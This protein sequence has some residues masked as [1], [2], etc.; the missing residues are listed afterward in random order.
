MSPDL[1]QI[2]VRLPAELRARLDELSHSSQ[3]SLSELIRRAVTMYVDSGADA[4][5]RVEAA[6][7]K[8]GAECEHAF[9]PEV[10]LYGQWMN[11]LH[12][13]ARNF[14]RELGDYLSQGGDDQPPRGMSP[15]VLTQ[16]TTGVF[17]LDF[18]EPIPVALPEDEQ[19]ERGFRTGYIGECNDT[20]ARLHGY[21][22]AAAMTGIQ[23]AAAL[24]IS[25][26]R[27]R[28]VIRRFL[29]ND[30]RIVG[31][32][33]R[34]AGPD[35]ETFPLHLSLFGTVR[36][37]HVLN[38][39]GVSQD[40]SL[41]QS[42][43]P[44]DPSLQVAPEGI[45]CVEFKPAVPTRGNP[46]EQARQIFRSG[47]FGPCS[48]SYCRV[49]G[50]E[51]PSE[52]DG[53]ALTEHLPERDPQNIESILAFVHSGYRMLGA[54][55]HTT[56]SHGKVHITHNNLVGHLIGD[57]LIRLWGSQQDISSFLDL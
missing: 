41:G 35:G 21:Q 39:W 24:P 6:Q 31:A 43:A 50:I 13:E 44:S 16:A 5:A 46:R 34:N 14:L 48:T 55:L 47:F 19:L 2:G 9:C 25:D 1:S 23:A 8:H 7:E 32:V 52:L 3:L 4:W 28:A 38:L 49:Y 17:R 15:G 57:E 18:E 45:W 11:S 22:D 56:G 37:G 12:D 51:N 10:Q 42:A 54:R 36:S 20:A 27:N 53:C 33:V 40:L 30:Y 26:P 29:R